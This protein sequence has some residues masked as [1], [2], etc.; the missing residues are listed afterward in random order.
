[1]QCL[2]FLFTCE[3]QFKVCQ[4][5]FFNCDNCVFAHRLTWNGVDSSLF[6]E[7]SLEINFKTQSFV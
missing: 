5:F 3:D 4:C 1:M 6:D 2:Q 7:L